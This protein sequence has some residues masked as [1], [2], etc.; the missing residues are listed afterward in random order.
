MNKFFRTLFLL[1][2]GAAIY[3]GFK[4]EDQLFVDLRKALKDEHET[5]TDHSDVIGGLLT[6]IGLRNSPEDIRAMYFGLGLDKE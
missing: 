1:A 2:V 5:S 6:E 4:S 3:K